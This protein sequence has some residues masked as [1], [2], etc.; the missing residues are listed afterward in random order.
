MAVR[1]A[2]LFQRLG[3]TESPP[4]PEMSGMTRRKEVPPTE[5]LEVWSLEHP[6]QA[7]SPHPHLLNQK[8]GAG[9]WLD[10]CRWLVLQVALC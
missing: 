6:Q 3:E 2:R 9:E 8:R 4:P 7:Q 1:Q 5:V 10:I